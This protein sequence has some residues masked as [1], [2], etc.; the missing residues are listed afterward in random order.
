VMPKH[1]WGAV[2]PNE[3]PEYFFRTVRRC[4]LCGKEQERVTEQLWG[5][6]TGYRWRPKVGR[7]SGKREGADKQ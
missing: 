7:C 4:R 2:H 1:E 3:S 5:R 6:V